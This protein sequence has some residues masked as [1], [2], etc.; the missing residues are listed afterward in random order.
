MAMDRDIQEDLISEICISTYK[1]Q[2]KDASL[3]IF[4]IMQMVWIKPILMIEKRGIE[5]AEEE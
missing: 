1:V 5:Q 4:S 2:G 3:K